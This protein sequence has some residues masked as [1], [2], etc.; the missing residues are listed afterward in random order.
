M[1]SIT[2]L[3]LKEASP[4]LDS[5]FWHS[6]LTQTRIRGH[7]KNTC[8][9]RGEGGGVLGVIQKIRVQIGGR[10]G[11]VLKNDTESHSVNVILKHLFK[12]K[13]FLLHNLLIF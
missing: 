1:S 11:G 4:E 3:G 8:S 9:N 7:S 5:D 2:I 6:V 13:N 10:G 12:L